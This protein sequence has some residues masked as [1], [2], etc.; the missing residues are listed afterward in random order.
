MDGMCLWL[1]FLICIALLEFNL[2][3]HNWILPWKW[4]SY[5]SICMFICVYN[6]RIA[7]VHVASAEGYQ[8]RWCWCT[9]HWEDTRNDTGQIGFVRAHPFGGRLPPAT[10][11]SNAQMHEV[12]IRQYVIRWLS[13]SDGKRVPT[14]RC[15]TI[16][17][18]RTTRN[19]ESTFSCVI[20][21]YD[22]F[23]CV[24][25]CERVFLWRCY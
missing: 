3:F 11:Y 25:A 16:A 6:K 24:R 4:A 14:A 5:L 15:V 17:H 2:S 21:Y 8:L 13:R 18:T 19:R 9:R 22:V 1:V 20:V 7:A 23:L 12:H 10:E